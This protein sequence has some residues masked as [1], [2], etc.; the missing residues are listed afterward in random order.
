MEAAD[1]NDPAYWESGALDLRSDPVDPGRQPGGI[2]AL[3]ADPRL[4]GHV[5]VATSGSTGEARWV[6]LSKAALLASARSVNA[7]LGATAAD[8]WLC[9]LPTHHV[10]GIG[11]LAR[12]YLLGREARVFGGR[13]RG[14]A[15]EFAGACG[16]EGITLT[17]LTPT[18]VY[19]LVS[20]GLAA[21]AQL[22][23]VIVGG[24]RLEPELRSAARGLGWPLLASYGMTE[25]AS[26]IATGSGEDGWL[27]V[28]PHWE[29]AAGDAGRLRI[30]GPAL[31]TGT[32]DAAGCF[33]AAP[34]DAEGWFET[35]DRVELRPGELRF[36]GR[37][38]DWVKKLGELVS[39][40]EARRR[41]EAL[42][43]PSGGSA[44]VV[45]IP[46]ARMG[47]RLVAVFEGAVD[48]G[49]VERFNATAAPY[50]RI[51]E[52]RAVPAFPRTAL[53]KIAWSRLT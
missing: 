33:A 48:P 7:F 53:G 51:D 36:L 27:P 16:R 31:F 5:L 25:A 19:D 13:W 24:G 41:L 45:A 47:H 46:D 43:R 22:R 11:V 23:A 2:E 40:D 26:Q 38:D 30:R 49:L 37:T 9:A 3:R 14:R 18:Q 15:R 20:E 44:T 12:A 34:V 50:A 52:S 39:L 29:V 28:L 8:R 17:S 21:P 6:A 35:R 42:A 1:L 32:V 4:A 10:G